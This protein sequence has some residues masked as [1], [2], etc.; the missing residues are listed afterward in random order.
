ME[1]GQEIQLAKSLKYMHF[2]NKVHLIKSSEK[3]IKKIEAGK[4][5]NANQMF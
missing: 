5:W 2:Y 3:P 1:S 4:L